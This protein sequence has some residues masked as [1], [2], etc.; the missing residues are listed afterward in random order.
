MAM[1]TSL[2]FEGIVK[3]KFRN[4]FEEIAL[5]GNWENIRDEK[6]KTFGTKY[7]GI[8]I[9]CGRIVSA[10][11]EWGDEIQKYD[12]NS[13]QWI[14]QCS[15]SDF[16]EVDSFIELLP[17]FI[18]IV[19]YCERY[20]ESDIYS[21]KYELLN[22]K[23]VMIT[24][25]FIKYGENMYDFYRRIAKILAKDNNDALFDYIV[26]AM[27]DDGGFLRSRWCY[28]EDKTLEDYD[29]DGVINT[30]LVTLQSPFDFE[31]SKEYYR[32]DN[33]TGE[34]IT[35]LKM[36]LFLRDLSN[37][38][39]FTD[40][41]NWSAGVGFSYPIKIDLVNETYEILERVDL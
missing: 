25:E 41:V 34:T 20:I 8:R 40:E 11:E 24:A 35:Q 26:H 30:A 27:D 32:K 2:R 28:W 36:Q 7:I 18:E 17:Y 14:F 6:I 38:E 23:V 9:P 10:P 4:D 21:K 16:Q 29:Q 15:T 22:D 31:T 5:H 37:E 1:Y 13:G 33:V 3:E 12:K 19:N 39:I